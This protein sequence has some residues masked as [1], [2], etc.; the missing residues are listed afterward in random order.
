MANNYQLFSAIVPNLSAQER[1]WA[2]RVLSCQQNVKKR[3]L[4]NGIK[5]CAIEADDWPGFQWEWIHED[6][7][8]WLYAEEYGNIGHVGEFV[9]AFLARFRPSNC[10]ALTWA[11]TCSRPRIGEFSG[12]GLFVTAKSL[13]AFTALDAVSR[14]RRRFERKARSCP[15]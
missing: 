13:R 1:D 7:D 2:N 3:L 9:R 5:P 12:G 8:L 14:M 10:W 6:H 11:Q 15:G 4:G